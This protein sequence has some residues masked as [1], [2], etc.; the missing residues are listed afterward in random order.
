[1]AFDLLKTAF[2]GGILALSSVSA[3]AQ[4]S[5]QVPVEVHL[6]PPEARTELTLLDEG[7]FPSFGQSRTEKCSYEARLDGKLSASSSQG[8]SSTTS[9]YDQ[10]GCGYD[11]DYS[12]PEFAVSCIAGMT[13]S[14][15]SD[16]VQVSNDVTVRPEILLRENGTFN[17]FLSEMGGQLAQLECPASQDGS[18]VSG[19]EFQLLLTIRVEPS[20]TL[21]EARYQTNIPIEVVY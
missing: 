1:M 12:A 10:Y 16:S 7:A 15:L 5:L 3:I 11:G 20:Q 17:L 13:V 14:L 19:D 4:D 2:A 21:E 9:G 6:Q 8:G 18:L